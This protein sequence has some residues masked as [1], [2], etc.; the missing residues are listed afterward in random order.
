MTDQ[1]KFQQA[2]R[3]VSELKNFYGHLITYLL[4]NILMV[5]YNMITS[6]NYWWFY[7]VTFGWG[8][9]ILSHA[10]RVFLIGGRL[11]REWEEKKIRE[12]ME[13]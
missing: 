8:F 1:E 11:G 13:K 2:Q 12:Y 10:A 9:G 3:R 5:V 4:I 7:W 6:P